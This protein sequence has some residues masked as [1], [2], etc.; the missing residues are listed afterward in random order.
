ME[1]GPLARFLVAYASGQPD[2]KTLVDSTLAKL[3]A[4]PAALFSTLGRIAARALETQLSRDRLVGWIEELG[5]NLSTGNAAHSQRAKVGPE[6]LGPK[7]REDSVSSRPRAGRWGTGWRSRTRRSRITRRW[8]PPRGMRAR[9]M[10][11]VSA[12]HT[13][14]RS[15]R[16]RWRIRSVH[17]SFSAQFTPSTRVWLA[18]S[19]WSTLVG[20]SKAGRQ[21]GMSG[22]RT[23]DNWFSSE[24]V[25][26]GVGNTILSDDGVG[27]HAARL[28]QDDPRVPAGVTILD[29]GTLG[30]ELMP[31]VSDA[32][33]VLFSMR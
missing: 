12:A 20:G 6:R 21:S 31:Y 29:G 22:D 4:P 32:S 2:V 11:T 17:L 19:T 1:V 25:V 27:V 5:N 18:P 14:L 23:M 33:R 10:P 3:K 15:L 8:C 9:E 16:R 26:V 13:K 24:T 7:R 28:L 30:L